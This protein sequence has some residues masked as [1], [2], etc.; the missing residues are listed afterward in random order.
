MICICRQFFLEGHGE[1]FTIP[2]TIPSKTRNL[3]ALG[4]RSP[5]VFDVFGAAA[6]ETAFQ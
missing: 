6:R 5:A 4:M 2:E 1:K 3:R